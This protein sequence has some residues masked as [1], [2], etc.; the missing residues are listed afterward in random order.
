MKILFFFKKTVFCLILIYYALFSINLN[1]F[2]C[3]GDGVLKIHLVGVL[4]THSR[5]YY[6]NFYFSRNIPPPPEQEF[7]IRRHTPFFDFIQKL[8]Y[9]YYRK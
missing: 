8:C 2:H 6:E 4:P 3:D 9:N 1:V 7:C 5:H